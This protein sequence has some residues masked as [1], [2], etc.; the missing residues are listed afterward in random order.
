MRKHINAHKLSIVRRCHPYWKLQFLV[1]YHMEAVSDSDWNSL[2]ARLKKY[3]K[4]EGEHILWTGCTSVDGYNIPI[5]FLRRTHSVKRLVLSL[6]QKELIN[7]NC[8]VT[9]I[10]NEKMCIKADHLDVRQK[11]TKGKEPGENDY[12]AAEIRLL[13]KCKK[14]SDGHL[15]FVTKDSNAKSLGDSR[16][17]FFGKQH[18]PHQVSWMV[19]NRKQIPKGM[20]VRHRCKE[21]LCVEPTHLE[22]GSARDNMM[23]KKR[24]KTNLEG[25]QHPFAKITRETAMKIKKSKGNGTQKERAESLSVTI[26]IV[27]QI[28]TGK[29]WTFLETD[30]DEIT[31]IEAKKEEQYQNKRKRI[32]DREITDKDYEK[33]LIRL[34][35]NCDKITDGEGNTH[36]IWNKFKDRDGYGK[37]AFCGRSTNTHILSWECTNKQERPQGMLVCHKCTFRACCNPECL[38][39]GTASK[40]M[41]DKIRDGT[42]CRGSKNGSAILNEE[43]VKEIKRFKGSHIDC[44][45]IFNKVGYSTIAD[46]RTGR[47]WNHIIVDSEQSEDK[48]K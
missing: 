24:D 32:E 22:I 30:P 31:K 6:S 16:I 14:S 28:D 38:E 40:N 29:S 4:K 35:E 25:E 43:E 12:I 13:T 19:A 44:A 45:K 3:S 33:G 20:V 41:N 27:S 7:S 42:D 8:F 15:L 46:I 2:E 48:T 5:T 26:A 21:K 9:N 11:S 47:S 23:D 1:L 18:F 36:W 10:C 37:T 39:V 34:Q 17:W